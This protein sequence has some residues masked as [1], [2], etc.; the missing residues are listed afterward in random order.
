MLSR[1]LS[2]SV[3]SSSLKHLNENSSQVKSILSSTTSDKKLKT[4]HLAILLGIP[5]ATLVT[6]LIYKY[7]MQNEKTSSGKNFK[8]IPTNTKSTFTNQSD[9]DVAVTAKKSNKTVTKGVSFCLNV[10]V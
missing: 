9:A 7:Y 3:S 5:S 8:E 4:W 10:C 6:Y 2:N 1:M